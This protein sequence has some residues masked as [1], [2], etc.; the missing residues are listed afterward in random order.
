MGRAI[1][2][3]ARFLE[4][5]AR[6]IFV[7]IVALDREGVLCLRVVVDIVIGTFAL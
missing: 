7:E 4:D 1:Y 3:I 5:V 6:V 2:S